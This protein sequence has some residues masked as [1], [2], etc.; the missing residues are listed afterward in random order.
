MKLDI[1]EQSLLETINVESIFQHLKSQCSNYSEFWKS[2]NEM[3]K[4]AAWNREQLMVAFCDVLIARLE[5]EIGEIP[6]E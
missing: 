3:R 1:T 2:L 4:E 6:I 5:K